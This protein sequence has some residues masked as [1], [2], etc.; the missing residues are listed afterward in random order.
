M[1]VIGL[2]GG[3]GT[4]KT[5]VS[6]VLGE[7]GAKVINADLLG[8]EAYRPNTQGWKE[9][10]DTFGE[11]ILAP[12]GEVDRKALGAIVF[13]DAAALQRLNAIVHPR[14]YAMVQERIDGL[15]AKGHEVAVVEA[16]LLVEAGWTDIADEVWVTT[17]CESAVVD[18]LRARDGL[19]ESAVS[20]RVRS[21]MDQGDR[22]CYAD[23]LI[24]N[25]GTLSQLRDS[26]KKLWET[27][28]KAS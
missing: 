9:I 27:R 2:T 1:F 7:L 4:G 13:G 24:E 21:Q 12:S 11:G 14:I 28:I 16:A 5:Q 6:R 22:V 20:V 26:V 18:R 25:E 10:I 19:V 15:A 3:I 17:S 23:A 8:H